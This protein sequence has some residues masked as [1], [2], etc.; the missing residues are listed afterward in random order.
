MLTLHPH[1]KGMSFID[2]TT[3]WIEYSRWFVIMAYCC[4]FRGWKCDFF[5]C[6]MMRTP[7]YESH[8]VNQNVWTHRWHNAKKQAQLY[9]IHCAAQVKEQ[10]AQLSIRGPWPLFSCP[11]NS[12]SWWLKNIMNHNESLLVQCSHQ[13]N[14]WRV[15]I[16]D[17]L[18]PWQHMRK[19][20]GFF[21]K[22]LALTNAVLVLNETENK[23]EHFEVMPLPL[24]EAC[25]HHRAHG[26]DGESVREWAVEWVIAKLIIYE[27]QLWIVIHAT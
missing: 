23:W 16:I 18:T 21:Q 12:M 10:H 24:G 15:P 25:L 17:W 11:Q 27:K 14:R 7:D 22:V 2:L 20:Y 4:T 6:L 8:R 26:E 9:M 3:S 13:E 19:K 1:V 5:D